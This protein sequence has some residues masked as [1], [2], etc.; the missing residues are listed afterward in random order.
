MPGN[1]GTERTFEAE[2]ARDMH[3]ADE[4]G[5]AMNKTPTTKE[6]PSAVTSKF[7]Q[8]KASLDES[9]QQKLPDE[10]INLAEQKLN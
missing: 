3:R 8:K 6:E 1:T 4:K 9:G 7:G 10:V 2:F 5:L